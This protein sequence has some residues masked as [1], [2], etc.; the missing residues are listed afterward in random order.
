MNFWE[1]KNITNIWENPP[2]KYGVFS[3]SS[4]RWQKTNR[5]LLIQNCFFNQQMFPCRMPGCRSLATATAQGGAP[6]WLFQS[7]VGM[8]EGESQIGKQGILR[9]TIYIYTYVYVY[10]YVYIHT[11]HYIALHYITLHCI[12]LH[13][14][15]YI[16]MCVCNF[17][18]LQLG[19]FCSGP[20]QASLPSAG[21]EVSTT[22]WARFLPGLRDEARRAG[23]FF[24]MGTIGTI[25]R[26]NKASN[27]DGY[28][29]VMSK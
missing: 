28:P 17:C 8:S 10:I 15:T 3:R 13:Y 14:I 27:K 1:K 19:F 26:W 22:R 29:L 7:W 5:C 24:A 11:L 21:G 9:Y 25:G 23:F 16:Y 18:W 20:G 12:A 4:F 6:D 2:K